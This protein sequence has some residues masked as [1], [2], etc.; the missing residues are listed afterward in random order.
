M[1]HVLKGKYGETTDLPIIF[2]PSAADSLN[3][4]LES[5]LLLPSYVKLKEEFDLLFKIIIRRPDLAE[6][7][8]AACNTACRKLIFSSLKNLL[9]M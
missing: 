7:L 9:Q 5:I 4:L 1:L 2:Y 6:E 3:K 8:S